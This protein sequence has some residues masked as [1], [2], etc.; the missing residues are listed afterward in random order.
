MHVI[1]NVWKKEEVKTKHEENIIQEEMFR[2][3]MRE[4]LKI[5]EMKLQIK[6]EEYEKR[7]N[8]VNEERP[9]AKLPEL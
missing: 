4:E 7:D 9:N 1:S 2:K 5:Q 8:T 6:S 3:R